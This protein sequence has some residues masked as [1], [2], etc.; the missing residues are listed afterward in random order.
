MV[1]FE[2]HFDAVGFYS[3]STTFSM[4]SLDNSRDM[5]SMKIHGE[6]KDPSTL[7]QRQRSLKS[8]EVTH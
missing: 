4:L 1:L 8:C 5:E 2:E 7:Q 3:V 6:H